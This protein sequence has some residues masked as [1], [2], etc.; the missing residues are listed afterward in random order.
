MKLYDTEI[1]WSWV[2]S[3]FNNCLWGF[4]RKLGHKWWCNLVI[5]Q[6]RFCGWRF[7]VMQL[8]ERNKKTI[9]RFNSSALI[10]VCLQWAWRLLDFRNLSP[11]FSIFF[12]EFIWVFHLLFFE[13]YYGGSSKSFT[14]FSRSASCKS[15]TIFIFCVVILKNPKTMEISKAIFW[16]SLYL[17]D[18]YL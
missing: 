1:G 13:E 10:F 12:K 4:I 8:C 9:L 2:I 7:C 18:L 6:R 15:V 5:I 3:S 16:C 17:F 11:E 14:L